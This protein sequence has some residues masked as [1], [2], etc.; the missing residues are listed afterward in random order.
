[1]RL[2]ARAFALTCGLVW[3]GGVFLLTWWMMA[4]EGAS[5]NVTWIGHLYRGYQL[6]PAGSLVGLAWAFPDGLVSGAIFAWLYNALG[7]VFDGR[8]EA[9]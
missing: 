8:A 5:G 7:R 6:S 1:M 2:N 4:F 3:G 9:G